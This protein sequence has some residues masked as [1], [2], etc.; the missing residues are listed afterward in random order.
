MEDG[1]ALDHPVAYGRH[2]TEVLYNALL[3]VQQ[4]VLHLGKGGGVIR[5]VHVLMQLP[6]IG[7][8]VGKDAPVKAYALAV[9]LAEHLF[10]VH[11]DKLIF[12]RGA[13]R[14]DYKNFHISLSFQTI[15]S[16]NRYS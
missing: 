3:R 5:Q 7:G 14:I 4:R 11:I 6:A 16:Y 1:P 13:A 12:E 15:I 9:A 8:L 2:L 10:P